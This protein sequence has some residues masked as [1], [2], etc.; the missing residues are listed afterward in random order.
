MIYTINGNFKKEYRKTVRMDRDDIEK[1]QDRQDRID[2][3]AN[4]TVNE[5][6]AGSASSYKD[7]SNL[8]QESN[9]NSNDMDIDINK[10]RAAENQISRGYDGS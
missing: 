2:I 10:K 4:H 1:T 5:Q 9:L 6:A 3:T 8:R 7:N